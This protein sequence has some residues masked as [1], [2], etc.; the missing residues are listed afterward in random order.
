M[1]SRISKPVS[2]KEEE[3]RLLSESVR[4]SGEL[5]VMPCS[6]CFKHNRSC[7]MAPGSAR[8]SE[9][10]SRGRSCNGTK[11]ASSRKLSFVVLFFWGC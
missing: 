10:I 8:C 11:V 1:S 2:K 5:A 9:C 4:L 6:S 7:L 3:R